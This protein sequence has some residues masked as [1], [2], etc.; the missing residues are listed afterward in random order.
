MLEEKTY[1][2]LTAEALLSEAIRFGQGLKDCPEYSNFLRAREEA[3]GSAA[4]GRLREE[5]L[6]LRG[7]VQQAMNSGGNVSELL[8]TFQEKQQ[9]FENLPEIK[10]LIQAQRQLLSLFETIARQ[11]N[12]AAGVD[13]VEANAVQ[14]SCCG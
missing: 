14:S 6:R 4:A 7:A 3:D 10:R 5:L 9:Q 1:P 2:N 12:E 13:F 8:K 11:I